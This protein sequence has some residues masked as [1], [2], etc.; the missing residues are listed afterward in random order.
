M[1]SIRTVHSLNAAAPLGHYSQAT[2]AGG[3]LFV[4]GLLPIEV[5]K[6]INYTQSFNEQAESVL[7]NAKEVLMAAGCGFDRV[8]KSTVYVTNVGNWGEFD[9]LYRK[10]F[11]EHRPARAVVPVHELHHGFNIELEMIALI[12][13]VENK[14]G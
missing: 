9:T 14:D 6:E 12:N 1:N 4:S 8:V 5:N 7:K 13:D 2:I 3:F 11:G 10:Y